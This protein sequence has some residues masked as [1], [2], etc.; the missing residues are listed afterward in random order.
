M[1]DQYQNFKKVKS[2]KTVAYRPYKESNKILSLNYTATYSG[3]VG[4]NYTRFFFGYLKKLRL[5]YFFTVFKCSLF[6]VIIKYFLE[7]KLVLF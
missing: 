7:K 1:F 2:P 3:L 6:C 4:S 5:K